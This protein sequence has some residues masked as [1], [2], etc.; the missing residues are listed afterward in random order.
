MRL[1]RKQKNRRLYDTVERRN[2]TLQELA[3]TIGAGESIRVEDGTTG[4][5][6]TRS[7][8]LQIVLEQEQPAGALLSQPFLEALIRLNNHPTRTLASGYLEASMAAF[9][10]Q[11]SE[12]MRRWQAAAGEHPAAAALAGAAQE[13]LKSWMSLQRT[14]FDLWSGRGPD[15]K[16]EEDDGPDGQDDDRRED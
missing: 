3:A 15:D 7:V 6:L 1:I 9:E 2:V 8:L 13:G 10:R 11:Q 4:E 5:D 16:A 14:L 12:L